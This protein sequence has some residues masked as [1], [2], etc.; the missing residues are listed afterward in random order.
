MSSVL[1]RVHDLVSSAR[2]VADH[3]VLELLA[4]VG[5]VAYGVLHVLIGWLAPRIAWFTRADAED[6]DQTGALQTV[7]GTP[8]GAGA[9]AGDRGRPAEPGAVAGR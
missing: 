8:G 6:A 1:Q 2:E 5:L 9:A 3:P 7:A 4:R